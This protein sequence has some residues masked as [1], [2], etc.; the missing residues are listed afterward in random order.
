MLSEKWRK[1]AK[2]LE[3]ARGK[4]LKIKFAIEVM[5]ARPEKLSPRWPIDFIQSNE[6]N[7]RTRCLRLLSSASCA[8]R[9]SSY[10]G[11]F[12]IFRHSGCDTK[13]TCSESEIR[14]A[15]LVAVVFRV[16]REIVVSCVCVCICAH[17]D[18]PTVKYMNQRECRVV[19]PNN[20]ITENALLGRLIR[21]IQRKTV[22]RRHRH[23][24]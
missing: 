5:V 9:R 14:M 2:W 20:K 13:Q 23:R 15:K 22:L 12:S 6:K 3:S 17:Y 16:A 21:L 24:V 8:P 19:L 10:R 11:V 7:K 18:E 4:W 1:C